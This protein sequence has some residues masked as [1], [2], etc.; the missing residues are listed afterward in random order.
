MAERAKEMR[1]HKRILKQLQESIIGDC[2]DEL[3]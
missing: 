2:I 3:V 1:E